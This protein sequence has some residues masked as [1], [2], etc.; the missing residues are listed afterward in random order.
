MELTP[1]KL[2]ILRR[3]VEEYVASGHRWGQGARRRSGLDVSSSTVRSELFELEAIGLLTHHTSAG[4][5]PTQSGY[6]VYAEGLVGE[7]EGRRAV[8]A[9][10]HRDAERARGGAAADDRGVVR[11]DPSAGA[12]VGAVA[13]GRRRAPRGGAA[14]P[15]AGRD[16][17]RDHCV[18]R[19]VEARFRVRAPRRP[20]C[21]GL[22]AGLPR[23]DDRR[24]AR[25]REHRSPGV[26]GPVAVAERTSLP[27]CRASCVRRRGRDRD[28]ALRGRCRGTARRRDRRRARG[29]SAAARGARAPRRSRPAARRAR[30]EADRDP[31][32]ARPRGRRAPRRLVRRRDL[33]L[34]NRSLGAVGLRAAADGLREGGPCRPRGGVRALAP[35]R[36]RVRGS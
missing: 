27:R 9:R 13:G 20:G 29:L 10:P 24:Q 7:I 22:G 12:R 21:R 1:R 28:R 5:V 18:G 35:R 19:G 6:R 25:E 30:P 14:A 26:R 33:R 2:E 3:V 36:G 34:P 11:R 23:R 4:R 32:R 16:R 15:V 31:H 17:R 8:P